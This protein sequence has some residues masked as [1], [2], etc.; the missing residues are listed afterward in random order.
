M[1]EFNDNKPIYRQIVD[2]AFNCIL[3]KFWPPGQLIPSVR[4]LASV[5]GVNSRTVM[6]ALEE[7]QE[8]G[9]I[10]PKRGMGFVLNEKASQKVMMVLRNEFFNSTL[11]ALLQEMDRLGISTQELADHM[12]NLSS[13]CSN[14]TGIKTDKC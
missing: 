4:E 11:P 1:M 10:E 14:P 8:L 6:K 9:M 13:A 7:L 12:N 5:L 2:Y 3:E